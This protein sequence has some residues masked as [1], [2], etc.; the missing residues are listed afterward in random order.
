MIYSSYCHHKTIEGHLQ[1]TL[2]RRGSQ[3][4]L[5]VFGRKWGVY[6]CYLSLEQ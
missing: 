5:N 3:M 2:Y 4:A 6:R 1:I